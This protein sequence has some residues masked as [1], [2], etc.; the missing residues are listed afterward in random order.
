L[1][2]HI[3]EADKLLHHLGGGSRANTRVSFLEMLKQAGREHA[4]QWLQQNYD[5]IGKRS[6][7][8]VVELFS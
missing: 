8:D 5:A 2:I 4:Q 7:I 3:I 1:R 6:S